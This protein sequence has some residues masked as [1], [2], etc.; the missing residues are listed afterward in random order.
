MTKGNLGML[1]GLVPVITSKYLTKRAQ[2]RT[3]R[4]WRINKKWLK[5][6]GMKDVPDLTKIYLMADKIICH[7][8]AVKLLEKWG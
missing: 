4:A 5:R 7:P 6:Y 2:A 1:Y 8:K 3:H